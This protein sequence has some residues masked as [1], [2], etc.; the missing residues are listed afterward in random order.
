MM[1]K[2]EVLRPGL[3]STIQDSGRFGH[4]EYGVPPGGAMDSSAA[5]MA[6]LLL[7]NE[8]EAAVL[9]ITQ[10]GPEL[11]FSGPTQIVLC[12]ADLSPK[13]NEVEIRNNT[14]YAVNT[15]DILN[16]G[17]RSSGHRVYLAV[18]GGFQTEIRLGSRSWFGGITAAARLE[19]G[20]NLPYL[21]TKSLPP[22]HHAGVKVDELGAYL[23]EVFPGPEFHLLT[24]EQQ[25]FL[26]EEKFSIGNNN[27]RMGIQLEEK[28]ANKLPSM[29]TAPVVPGTVQ[30][31]PSG[32]IVVIMK[33]GQ[34]T[35]GYPRILHLSEIGMCRIAQRLTGE[36][37]EFKQNTIR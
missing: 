26:T 37:I 8:P 25:R 27:N 19:K 10:S 20:M 24:L 3:F 14:V 15:G 35:G 16:F 33:D 12:G 13:Q 1:G 5:A 6:N 4:R 2:A 7:Q 29:I 36:F 28:I 18:K 34:T 31:T 22:V 17:M 21:E 30:L 32:K 11:R 9:E 23:V